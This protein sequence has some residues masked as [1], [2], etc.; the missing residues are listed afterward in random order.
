MYIHDF[1]QNF[2]KTFLVGLHGDF[3]SF[4]IAPDMSPPQAPAA[5]VPCWGAAVKPNVSSP[6]SG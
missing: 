2:L 1:F 4:V 6:A 5:G 3:T